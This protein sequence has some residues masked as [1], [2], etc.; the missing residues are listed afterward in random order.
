MGNNKLLETIKPDHVFDG[1]DLDCGSGLVLLIREN[2]QK[3]PVGGILEMRS[4]EATVCDELP[5]WCRMV[6]HEYLGLLG[7]PEQARYFIRKN[8]KQEEEEKA[9]ADD[10]KKAKEYEWRLR[11]RATGSLK[12]TVYCR[13]FSFDVGQAAS[14]EE[15][16]QH[17]S[18]IEYLVGALSASLSTS[19]STESLKAGLDVDDVEITARCKLN[20]DLAHLGIEEG[21]PSISTINIKCFITSMDHKDKVMAVWDDVVKRSPLYT[22]LIKSTEINIKVNVV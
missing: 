6:G 11:T 12:S 9:L 10:K 15:K 16:D 22:T 19:F 14:F 20:N 5:P 4:L 21:D 17:P 2:M 3:V 8:E 13:N 7:S 18:A 1:G